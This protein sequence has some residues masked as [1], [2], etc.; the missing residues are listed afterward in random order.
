MADSRSSSSLLSDIDAL[1]GII[2]AVPHPVFVKDKNSR[3]V[4]L[5]DTMCRL[6]GR[7]FGELIGKSDYDFF[8]MEQADVFRKM[9]L[10]VLE[11]G[12]PNENEEFFSDG[13]GN[14]R[15]IVTQKKRL[16]LSDGEPLLIGCIT[17]I[18]DFRRAEAQIRHQAHHDALTGLP[19]RRVFSEKVDSSSHENGVAVLFVDLDHFKGVNDTLGHAIGD[20]VLKV[21]ARRL[22]HCCRDSDIV[23][24][25]G[26]DEFAILQAQIQQ[27]AD[28]AGLAS[29]I[30]H[31]IAEPIVIEDH[32]ILIGASVGIAVAPFDGQD[33]PLVDQERRFGA[34]SRKKRWSQ[35]ILFL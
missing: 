17:D 19:N 23:A 8:P 9:D 12:E 10:R 7:T 16:L 35:H 27:A 3:F 29:R 26:G 1:R 14:I 13:E 6:M 2:D 20:E 22:L 5:N 34:V 4:I 30:V 32:Q 11:T 25:F 15:T 21:A 31:A 33:A 28:A 18:S 24:R